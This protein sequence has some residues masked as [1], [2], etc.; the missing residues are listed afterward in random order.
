MPSRSRP[1]STPPR[2]AASWGVPV[3]RTPAVGGAALAPALVLFFL[4]ASPAGVPGQ[5]PAPRPLPVDT[6]SDPHVRALIERAREARSGVA[7]G[8][9]S[10]DGTLWERIYVGLSATRFRRERGLFHQERV[11]RIR[12]SRDGNHRVRWEGARQDIP[13]AGLSSVDEDPG[14]V[15]IRVEVRDPD[16]PPPEEPDPD[17]PAEP[18]APQDG[19]DAP[20]GLAGSLAR[21]LAGGAG[22]PAPLR[23]EPGSDRLVFGFSGSGASGEAWALHPLA[24]TAGLHYRY[25][26]GDTLRITLPDRERPVT[27]SEVRVE[28]RRA[29]FELLTASLWFDEE[30]GTLVRT[31]YRP[32]R[33][34]S[35]AVDRPDDA[36]DVPRLLRPIEFEI[37]YVTVDH[38]L[39]DFR[40]WIPR[41]FAFE[42]E[43]RVGAFLR[44][45]A[46]LE[47]TVSNLRANEALS[48]E[49]FPDEAPPGWTLA[50]AREEKDDDGE[51]VSRVT[52]LVPPAHRLQEHPMLS[53][54]D[55]RDGAAFQAAELR[56][57]E[58]RIRRL[59]PGGASFV[60]GFAWGLQEGMTRFNRV[61]G[62]STGA[63]V[64]LPLRADLRFRAEARL[65]FADLEPNGELH[66]IRGTPSR[67]ASVGA[68]RRLESASEWAPGHTLAHS[69]GTVLWG[70]D[71]TPWYRAAGG[72]LR[73]R[74][75]GALS[76]REARLFAEGHRSAERG[77]NL[78][79]RRLFSNDTLALNPPATRGGWGGVSVRHRWQSGVSPERVR[80]FTNLRLEGATGTSEYGR[81]WAGVGITFPLGRGMAAGLEGAAGATVGDPPDQRLFH[82]GGPHG[83]RGVHSGQRRGEAF[84]LGRAEVAGGRP[85]ARLTLF[86]D[87]LHTGPRDQVFNSGQPE[88]VVGVGAA[89]LDGL[90]RVDVARGIRGLEGWRLLA[91][92]DGIL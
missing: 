43:V 21:S 56:E 11:A 81:G 36:A 49:V 59:T 30:T 45:P 42:G 35:L 62:L 48:E 12:W 92:L 52:L 40:W 23:H 5:E 26:S 1:L 31:T 72:E 53:A 58:R 91:Y 75:D 65:G 73:L 77:T 39:F 4:F 29:A 74:R 33:A 15:G 34:F 27:L 19:E 84:W 13:I 3:S 61:E 70:S 32:S 55:D 6:Y 9:E 88:A 76:L 38:G 63:A 68:Y 85:A 90:F 66:L 82:P 78:H 60:P 50:Y 54:P 22:I 51:I 7:E 10:Y 89:F 18:A 16:D 57:L 69:L 17:A 24:D 87:L 41:R 46:S 14:R 79:L 37:R 8:L 44:L 64:T 20:G 83:F 47:W 86:G 25:R 28:P 2:P 71:R 67:G 80:L